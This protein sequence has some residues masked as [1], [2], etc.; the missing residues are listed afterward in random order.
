MAGA[1]CGGDRS[2]RLN[3]RPPRPGV[4]QQAADVYGIYRTTRPALLQLRSSGDLALIIP[5]E[6]V[7]ATSGTYR[8]AAGTFEVTTK[9]CGSALGRYSVEVRGKQVAGDA[10]LVFETV[11]DAC[12]ERSKYLTIDPWYYADS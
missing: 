11:D 4:P 5:A 6:G 2:E 9:S 8:L 7:G 12:S 3:V 1:A 10:Y